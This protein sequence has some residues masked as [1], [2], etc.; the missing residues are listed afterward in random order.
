MK[1]ELLYI[2]DCPNAMDYLPE[3][4]EL[5]ASVG[6]DEP[7]QL[8][9]IEDQDQAV[10]ERFVGSPTVRVDGVDVDPSAAG[11]GEYA[12]SCRLY[13]DATVTGGRPPADWVR[14]ALERARSAPT[15]TGER[16]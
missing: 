6:V 4:Q 8:T 1:V 9:L 10:A 16:Q 7:V 13:R 12:I 3:L 15:A 14:Q 11:R 2:R 5:L